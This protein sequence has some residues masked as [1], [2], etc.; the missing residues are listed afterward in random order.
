MMRGYHVTSVARVGRGGAGARGTWAVEDHARAM[1]KIQE[2]GAR[3]RTRRGKR[4]AGRED[5]RAFDER[6]T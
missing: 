1:V 2:R 6:T 5:A 3:A 4:D